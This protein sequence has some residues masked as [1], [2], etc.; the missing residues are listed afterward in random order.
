MIHP[1]TELRFINE[2]INVCFATYSSTRDYYLGIDKL[3]QALSEVAALPPINREP[4]KYRYID[5]HETMYML[6][7]GPLRQPFM[8]S[9]NPWCWLWFHLAMWTSIRRGTD[10][11]L[12]T[13]ELYYQLSVSMWLCQLSRYYQPWSHTSLLANLG[14]RVCFLYSNHHSSSAF[15]E[16]CFEKFCNRFLG[17]PLSRWWN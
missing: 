5:H 9:H 10:L 14:Y 12:C 6:G 15:M 8:Q 3:D 2:E 11:W 17:P 1:N 4:W 16:Y 13:F 7:S